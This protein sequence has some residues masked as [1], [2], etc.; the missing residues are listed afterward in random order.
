MDQ[1]IVRLI[2]NVVVVC[3]KK[4]TKKKKSIHGRREKKVI[5]CKT[6]PFKRV[7]LP[8]RRGSSLEHSVASRERKGSAAAL[9]PTKVRH[10]DTLYKGFP[11][12]TGLPTCQHTQPPVR[13]NVFCEKPLANKDP[14][15]EDPSNAQKYNQICHGHP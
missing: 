12:N 4:K 2:E 13:A 15:I 11:P 14:A 1:A 6:F 9:F 8:V 7:L 3:I 10:F 5:P